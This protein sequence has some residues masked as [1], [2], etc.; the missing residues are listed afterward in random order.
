MSLV[1]FAVLFFVS[2]AL[3]CGSTEINAFDESAVD[4]GAT[5]VVRIAPNLIVDAVDGNPEWKGSSTASRPLTIRLPSGKHTVTL[6]FRI[7]GATDQKI[8]IEFTTIESDPVDREVHVRAGHV[9]S[10]DIRDSGSGW[11][12]T[13]REVELPE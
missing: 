7:D 5:A 12:P 10:I 2:F 8:A 11:R 9:Y 13:F 1:R 4:P 3:G 6:R